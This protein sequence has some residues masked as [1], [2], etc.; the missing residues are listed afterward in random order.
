[1]TTTTTTSQTRQHDAAQFI[2]GRVV[3]LTHYLPPYM[4][5]VLAEAS[6]HVRDF[7]VLLSTPLEPNRQFETDWSGLSVE[8]QKSWMLRRPWKHR[9]GFQDELYV[10]FPYDTLFQL[11]RAQP[12]I[13]FSFELG[14]RSFQSLL[15][16][17]RYRRCRL[18][19]CVC[20]SEHTEQGRGGLRSILRRLLLKRADAITYNGPSC[21][22]YLK[23]FA[24]PDE[25]LF[26]FPYAAVTDYAYNGTLERST[27][28]A[29][30]FVCVGQL[31]ERKGVV[32]LVSEFAKYCSQ[33][34]EERL[35]LTMI[36]SG[37]MQQQLEQTERTNNFKLSFV[38]HVPPQQLSQE[39]Q[40][41]GVLVFPTLADE[42]GLVVNEA[43]QAGLPVLGSCFGQAS[44]TLIRE[45]ANGWVYNPEQPA[46][47]HD[48]LTQINLL[49]PIQLNE[50]RHAARATVQDITSINS[51]QKALTMFEFLMKR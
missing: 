23:Q 7:R 9:A 30:R 20:V 16:R 12:D 2:D 37:P 11:R 19:L 5:A 35:D 40:K 45:G 29:K 47:L 15:H 6:Q 38:G 10:H 22:A 28:N 43:M 34:P 21:L 50:M 42:W 14:F 24:V 33:Y 27:E 31:I 3:T 36:G 51:A 32:P 25:K 13:I 26:H 4:K 44:P 48:K 41:Y 17:L 46:Q 8:V 1:M 49:S 39:L 18:A